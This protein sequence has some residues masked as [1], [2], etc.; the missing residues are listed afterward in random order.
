MGGSDDSSKDIIDRLKDVF[1][2]VDIDKG[3]ITSIGDN[4]IEQ[5]L[6]VNGEVVG[7]ILSVERNSD[8]GEK[9]EKLIKEHS[10]ESLDKSKIN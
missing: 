2:D 6:T 9:L 4:H 7:K 3:D 5:D 1:G 10:D 8:F